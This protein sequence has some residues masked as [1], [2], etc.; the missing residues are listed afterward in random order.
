MS[1]KRN[2]NT[3]ANGK[4]SNTSPRLDSIDLAILKVLQQGSK[5]T[6]AELAER[7]GLSPPSTLERVKKLESEG[8]IRQYVALVDPDKIN[9][10]IAVIVH[11]SLGQHGKDVLGR[12]REQF[13]DMSEV[14]SCWH[15][16]GEDDFILK[17]LVCDMSGYEQFVVEK[18]SQIQEISRVRSAFVLTTFKE[19]TQIPLTAIQ[20][21]R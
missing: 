3:N 14:L 6:N 1:N 4:S 18:L 5:I 17:V 16:A 7:V 10:S 19:T 9:Q 13:A 15:T 21:T 2:Q 11:I 20:A 8:I 12:V